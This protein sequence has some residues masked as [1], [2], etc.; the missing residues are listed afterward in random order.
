MKNKNQYPDD[1]LKS[2]NEGT[3]EIPEIYLIA[4]RIKGISRNKFIRYTTSITGLVALGNL[5]KSCSDEESELD[6]I[7]EENSCICHAVCT[8]NTDTG[9]D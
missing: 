2:V 4:K 9:D 3:K 6:I 1:S 5:L 8:C 7:T